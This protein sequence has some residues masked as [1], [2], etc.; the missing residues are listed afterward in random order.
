MRAASST[1][2][3]TAAVRV[4]SRAGF[5][6]F[7]DF[8]VPKELWATGRAKCDICPLQIL[9]CNHAG[10]CPAIVQNLCVALSSC[11]CCRLQHR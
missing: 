5:I 7:V 4:G 11:V 10:V 1:E 3:R 6:A 8:C 9:L 2:C